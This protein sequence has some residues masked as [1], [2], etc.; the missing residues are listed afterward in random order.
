MEHNLLTVSSLFI[1]LQQS[2]IILI[3]ICY[4]PVVWAVTAI[5]IVAYAESSAREVEVIQLF[6]EMP[7]HF[8][9][10]FAPV[11]LWKP[12]RP[13]LTLLST[14]DTH[15]LTNVDRS[16]LVAFSSEEIELGEYAKSSMT[17]TADQQDQ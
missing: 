10:Q 3:F 5:R 6:F 14:N 7:T 2:Y 12:I 9:P 13:T 8:P 17:H 11:K 16:I 4:H 1:L 15:T